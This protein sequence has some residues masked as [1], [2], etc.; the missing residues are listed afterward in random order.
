M[1]GKLPRKYCP[2]SICPLQAGCAVYF[3]RE[4]GNDFDSKAHHERR[5]IEEREKK[6][7]EEGE[8]GSILKYHTLPLQLSPPGSELSWPRLM[9]KATE[10]IGGHGMLFCAR[11]RQESGLT[12]AGGWECYK[13]NRS[14]SQESIP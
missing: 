3:G 2:A 7:K 12:S 1:E 8:E 5:N 13:I 9:L 4:R 6:K 11:M 10:H 14:A